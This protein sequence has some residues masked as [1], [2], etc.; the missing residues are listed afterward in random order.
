MGAIYKERVSEIDSFKSMDLGERKR[1]IFERVKEISSHAYKKV[2][3][4]NR[5]YKAAGVRPDRF[6]SFENLFDLPVISKADLQEVDID[7]RSCKTENKYVANTG[8]TSG[9]P[10][11]FYIQPSSIGHEWAHMHAIWR[12]LGFRQNNLKMLLA[13]RAV[14]KG[15]AQYDSI[16]HH[17]A[18]NIYKGWSEVSDIICDL[19]KRYR[20]N[21]L[22]GYP[23]AIFDLILWASE[24]HREL[25][26]VL[27]DNIKGLLLGSEYPSP[28]LRGK[29]ESLINAQSISWYG[30]TERAVLARELVGAHGVYYP[31]QTYGFCEALSFE[32]QHHLLGTSYYN[33]A[34]PLIRYDT[35]DLVA[36][37]FLGELLES[38]SVSR[39]RSGEYIFDRNG[40]KVFLTA[41]IFG[42]HH[43]AFNFCSSVQVSQQ[44]K[45]V[46]KIFVVLIGKDISMTDVVRGFDFSDVLVDFDFFV[47]SEP[48]KTKSGKVSLLIDEL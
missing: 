7:E 35:G 18:V 48:K 42:R 14:I 4:Y 8:G 29:V 27:T 13:G 28:V 45:G 9:N 2:P 31:F 23:S 10:L 40:N 47:V 39:G 5:V 21:Y 12:D 22:H 44:R 3:F 46:A 25:L 32:G 34:S 19:I 20:I 30:H 37:V 17:F 33:Y 36:P 43:S 38:F 6:D 11:S 1:F 15:L 26:S 41:L 24:N 16:R